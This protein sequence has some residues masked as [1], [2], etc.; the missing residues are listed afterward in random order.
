MR[1]ITTTGLDIAKH[2]FQVHGVDAAGNVAIRRRLRRGEVLKFF[3][4]LQPTL[5]GIEVKRDAD[6]LLA[7]PFRHERSEPNCGLGF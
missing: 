1:E 6:P 2:V 4:K 3:A 7:K 5:V